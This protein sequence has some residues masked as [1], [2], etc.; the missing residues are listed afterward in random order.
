MR[1]E[2]KIGICDDC[3]EDREHIKGMC[4]SYFMPLRSQPQLHVFSRADEL[5][6]S[7]VL[8]E[9][10][11]LF[12][13]IEMEEGQSGFDVMK[14]MQDRRLR[15]MIIYTTSHSELS[16]EGYGMRVCGF[17]TKPIDERTFSERLASTISLISDDDFIEYLQ[18][19]GAYYRTVYA[20]GE[21]DMHCGTLTDALKKLEP[22]IFVQCHRAYIANFSHVTSFT[23]SGSEMI[24]DNG[25][26]VLVSARRRSQVR[27]AYSRFLSMDFEKRMGD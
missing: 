24:M 23:D 27:K 14:H 19:D 21:S 20:S 4:L 7:P 8:S 13:D 18:A 26:H 25:D 2:Y 11:I 10:D 12:L 15:P 16:F 17:L 6:D 3:R 9:L 22:G 5:L 1:N